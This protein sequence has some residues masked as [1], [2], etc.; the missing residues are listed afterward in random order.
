MANDIIQMPE[1]FGT[2][3]LNGTKVALTPA[4]IKQNI[5]ATLTDV[6]VFNFGFLCQQNNLNPFT[7]GIQAGGG[8][9]F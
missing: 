9:I 2:Y 7:R 4:L 3:D 1:N 5:C 6:E 8:D